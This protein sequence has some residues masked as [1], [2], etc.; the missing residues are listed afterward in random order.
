MI[1]YQHLSDEQLVYMIRDDSGYEYLYGV[2]INRY[3]NRLRNFIQK[4]FIKDPDAVEDV[5]QEAFINAYFGLRTFDCERKLQ[6]WIYKIAVNVALNHVNKPKT[7]D[8]E[9]F[10]GVYS[11]SESLEEQFD[12]DDTLRKLDEVISSLD[13]HSQRIADLYFRQEYNCEEISRIMEMR[14]PVVRYC[15]ERV[16]KLIVVSCEL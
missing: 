15:L 7:V 12:A 9:G 3:S 13:P 5:V 14:L 4:N 11:S 10:L 16:R 1:K 8:L 6:A 2:I